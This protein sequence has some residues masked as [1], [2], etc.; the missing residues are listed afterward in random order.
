MQKTRI[1]LDL[2]GVMADF[3]RHFTD[4]FGLPCKDTP[5]D[6]KWPLVY[7]H[8]TFFRTMPPCDGAREFFDALVGQYGE[9]IILTA[10]PKAPLYR[11]SAQQKRDWV[12]EHLSAT[13]TVLP[14]MGGYNKGLFMHAPGDILIDDYRR[15][16]EAWEA[17]GG[18]AI[19]HRNWYDTAKQLAQ[20]MDVPEVA[21]CL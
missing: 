18:R 10:C 12:R 5:D 20:M 21:E 14:V 1:Y 6:V 9:P 15:N 7:G 17:D 19:L 16:T 11:P 4:C 2:D 3:D 13:A 8:G